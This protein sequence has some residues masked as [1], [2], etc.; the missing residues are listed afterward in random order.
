MIEYSLRFRYKSRLCATRPKCSQRQPCRVLREWELCSN[1]FDRSDSGARAPPTVAIASPLFVKVDNTVDRMAEQAPSFSDPV[2]ALFWGAKY[3]IGMIPGHDIVMRYIASS[4]QNDPVRSLL[5]LILFFYALR[6]ILQDRTRNSSNFVRLTDKEID[7]LV[8]EFE[9]E[10]LCAPL[11][12]AEQDDLDGVPLIVGK[13]TARP[14]V[15]APWMTGTKPRKMLNLASFNFTGLLEAPELTA[16]AQEVL[17]EYGVGSCSPPGFYGTSDMH[18]RLEERL[19][20]FVRRPA[21]IVY[22]QG[23]STISSVIPAFCKRGDIIVADAGVNFAIQKGLQLSRST[24]YWYEHN[25]MDSLEM[26]LRQLNEQQAQ[27]KEPLTR[28][29]IVS[30]ALFEKYGSIAN[31]PRLVEL[32]SKYKFRLM[33]DES[34]SMGVLGATGRGLT[35]AQSVCPD[36]VDFITGNLA[37]SFATA[38]GFC[39]SSHEAVRHQRING[40]SFVFSAAM[41]VM[42]ANGSTVAM[43]KLTAE[44]E[45]FEQLALNVKLVRSVLDALPMVHIPSAATSPLIHVQ[46]RPLHGMPDAV[47]DLSMVQQEELLREIERR[48]INQGVLVCRS[49]QLPAIYPASGDTSPL[50]RP[51]LQVVVSSALTPDETA[52]AA[53][54]LRASIVS[55]LAARM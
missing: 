9:P 12:A 25:N 10:P 37:V 3:L 53:D 43:D 6:T 1:S 8:Q 4:Y 49:R 45:L 39:A 24:L 23:L 2:S 51:S 54:V 38:G 41:P 22:S 42:M 28:R 32:K 19:A 15:S 17:R 14:M 21:A 31:L 13:A 46:V 52:Q 30:E 20:A 40:L 11:T 50:L 47:H 33:L 48:T 29:F 5:E 26:K 36:D 55:V 44:P 18:M 7:Y 27:S 34:Y 16:Q 35:E